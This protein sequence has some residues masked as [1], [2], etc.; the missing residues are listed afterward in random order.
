MTLK[1]RRTKATEFF[2][3]CLG[4]MQS[5]GEDYSKSENAYS[6][7]EKIANML[8]IPIRK[9]FNFFIACKIARLEELLTKEPNNE[10][11]KDTMLD[12]C[13]YSCLAA[14]YEEGDGKNT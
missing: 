7:F 3:E 1:E 2:N 10:S 11:V 13:N 5:K 6:N 4:I 9:V 8:D 14:I 12:L